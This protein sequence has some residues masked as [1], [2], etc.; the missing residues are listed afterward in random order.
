MSLKM[1]LLSIYH[2][3]R[4]PEN[5]ADSRLLKRSGK[6]L[7]VFM[8]IMA[9]LSIGAIWLV[10]EVAVQQQEKMGEK[11]AEE[12]KQNESLHDWNNIGK[13]LLSAYKGRIKSI[14]QI[15]SMTCWAVLPSGTSDEEALETA[16]DIGN[17]IIKITK[18]AN[19]GK[20][21]VHTVVSGK[22]IAVARP[23]GMEYFGQIQIKDWNP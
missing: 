16:E 10:S 11:N 23:S 2:K 21:M 12:A 7:F 13:K 1:T 19:G 18:G 14:N 15:N 5:T 20:P 3:M 4:E 17:F 6:C 9:V 22:R 8:L